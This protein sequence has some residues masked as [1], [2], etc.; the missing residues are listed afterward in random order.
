MGLNRRI[1]NDIID[2]QVE[3]INT[4]TFLLTRSSP[5]ITSSSSPTTT[6]TTTEATTTG[7][8][9]SAAAAAAAAA[10]QLHPSVRFLDPRIQ[11][12][13]HFLERNL[14]VSFRLLLLL[15]IILFVFLKDL[16]RFEE[17]LLNLNH[18][19]ATQEVIEANT[20]PYTFAKVIKD[21]DTEKCTICLSEFEDSEE[22][23]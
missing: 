17:S 9:H 8:L 15:V 22:V 12:F 13:S 4:N 7:Q 21:E 11:R 16:M 5:H 10:L 3:L 20:L 19:G 1:L 6:A 23:R 18:R 2:T 14:D